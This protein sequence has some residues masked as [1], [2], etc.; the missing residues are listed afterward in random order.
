MTRGKRSD[1]YT[2]KA[3]AEGRP[4]RSVYKLE[5]IERR[6]RMLRPGARVLDCGCAPGSWTQFAAERVGPS[7]HVLGLDLKPI[8]IPLPAWA[9]AR[10]G[11]V[12]EIDA[13]EL[14]RFDVVLSDMAPST[15][16]DHR[17]DALRSAGLAEK[18]L[19]LGQAVLGSGGATVIKVLEGAEVPFLV[20]S[21]Q[22]LFKRVSRV[23]PDATRKRSR[24][25]FL[26]GVG[27]RRSSERGPALRS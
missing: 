5:E 1:H 15:S 8:T 3:R 14:G 7:G 25:I 24:E 9:D 2:R 19:E 4:A 17:T 26:V 13:A 16:G 10:V 6:F 12:F 18:T 23:R 20:D 22:K 11:D 21:M 27:L